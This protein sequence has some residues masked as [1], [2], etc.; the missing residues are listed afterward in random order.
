MLT[1]LPPATPTVNP[2]RYLAQIVRLHPAADM[3]I[4]HQSIRQM[5]HNESRM[6]I[7]NRFARDIAVPCQ[8]PVA[9]GQGARRPA[10]PGSGPPAGLGLEPTRIDEMFALHWVGSPAATVML[11]RD[12]DD[13]CGIV[14]D[15]GHHAGHG[16]NTSASEQRDEQ[17]RHDRP[18]HAR[19]RPEPAVHGDFIGRQ[20]PYFCQTLNL[21]CEPNFIFVFQH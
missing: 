19:A 9:A 12:G 15:L 20:S 18:P 16:Q 7:M 11:T 14:P 13:L 10:C 2:T 5:R 21:R 6:P 8:N 1:S 4:S 17:R 3:L